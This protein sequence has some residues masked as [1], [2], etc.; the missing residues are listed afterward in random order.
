[1]ACQPV[2]ESAKSQKKINKPSTGRWKPTEK[3]LFLAM[4]DET[5]QIIASSKQRS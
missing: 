3:R 5:D 2:K 1:M 4:L